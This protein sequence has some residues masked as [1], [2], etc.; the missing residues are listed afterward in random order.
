[1]PPTDSAPRNTRI[2]QHPAVYR[3]LSAHGFDEPPQADAPV[4]LLHIPKTG[5]TFLTDLIIHNLQSRPAPALFY[6]PHA[7]SA[8]QAVEVFGPGTRL[9]LVLRDPLERLVSAFYSRRRQGRP[10]YD[11]PWTE[12]EAKVFARYPD[13]GAIARAL[14]SPRPGRR[15]HARRALA[16]MTLVPRDYAHAFGPATQAGPLIDRVTLCP[17]IEALSRKLDA[18]MTGLGL[19]DY[20]LP[21]R[22]VQN[23]AEPPPPLNPAERLILRRHLREDYRVHALLQARAAALGQS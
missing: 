7:M 14:A 19:P 4:V 16:S 17:P 2:P 20:E 3:F 9:A 18:I 1:M 6:A 13:L 5:G 15:Q 12:A 8:A 23:R 11:T 10:D 22:P 21:P